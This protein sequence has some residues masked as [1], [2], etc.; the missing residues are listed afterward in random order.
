MMASPVWGR[1]A[2]RVRA[3]WCTVCRFLASLLTVSFFSPS[4]GPA[5]ACSRAPRDC[6][7]IFM[8]NM[9]VK[10]VKD[11]D[12]VLKYGQHCLHF[13]PEGRRRHWYVRMPDAESL[14]EWKGVFKVCMSTA[15]LAV[16]MRCGVLFTSKACPPLSWPFPLVHMPAWIHLACGCP[17][18]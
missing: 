14:K 13:K 5:G 9:K 18:V 11:E 6:S 4:C 12:E 10:K 8:C 3:A 7:R 2:C 17:P 1:C 16:V 15:A